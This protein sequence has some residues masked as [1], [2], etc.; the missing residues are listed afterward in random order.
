[1]RRKRILSLFLLVVVIV[2]GALG[3]FLS[4]PRAILAPE[5]YRIPETNVTVQIPAGF[6]AHTYT[7]LFIMV[8][9]YQSFATPAGLQKMFVFKPYE[10]DPYRGLQSPEAVIENYFRQL[11]PEKQSFQ[12]FEIYLAEVKP[13]TSSEYL[14]IKGLIV[15]QTDQFISFEAHGAKIESEAIYGLV[16]AMLSSLRIE[17]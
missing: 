1:M 16:E 3:F 2:L 11:Q 13:K 17:E 15:Y 7:S 12:D 6:E 8:D 14:F 4:L 9:I 10:A 5:R